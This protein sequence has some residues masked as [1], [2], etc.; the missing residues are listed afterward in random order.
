VVSAPYGI[1]VVQVQKGLQRVTSVALCDRWLPVNFRYA[2]FTTEVV[3]RC[4]MSRRATSGPLHRS[5]HHM[6]GTKL[7]LVTVAAALSPLVLFVSHCC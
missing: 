4:K 3:C 1:P 7:Q 2:P 5:N 6:L